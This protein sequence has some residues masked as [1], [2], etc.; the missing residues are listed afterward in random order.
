VG[1]DGHG[2]D[3]RERRQRAVDQAGHGGLRPLQKERTLIALPVRVIALPV[4]LC[5]RE[6]A[7]GG[8]LPSSKLN[9]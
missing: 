4:C 8:L 7:H 3:R 1:G 5:C 6:G 9:Y 2:E